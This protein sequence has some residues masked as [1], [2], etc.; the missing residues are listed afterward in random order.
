MQITEYKLTIEGDI[1]GHQVTTS[2][3]YRGNENIMLT[4]TDMS[5]IHHE[6]ILR[7]PRHI[8][9]NFMEMIDA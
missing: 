1:H 2:L 3:T 7:V 9:K 4:S 5:D 6:K 8:L